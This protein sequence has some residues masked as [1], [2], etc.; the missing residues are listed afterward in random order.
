MGPC[1]Y[2]RPSH[3]SGLLPYLHI[4]KHLKELLH[5]PRL[6][7]PKGRPPFLPPLCLHGELSLL[8]TPRR[9][10]GLLQSRLAL[11][12]HK[13]QHRY[14]VLNLLTGLPIPHR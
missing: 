13:V 1:Q 8:L 10:L 12:R 4:R 2:P 7:P 9:L 14:Q 3:P 6:S 5:R 11:N